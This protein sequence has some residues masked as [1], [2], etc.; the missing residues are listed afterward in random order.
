MLLVRHRQHAVAPTQNGPVH[1]LV[2]VSLRRAFKIILLVSE[3]FW[4]TCV[5]AFIG[6]TVIFS[7]G[8]TWVDMD[9]R[10]NVVAFALLRCFSFLL[11]TVSC[12]LNPLIYIL[13][14]KD[15]RVGCRRMLGRIQRAIVPMWN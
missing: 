6:R 11:T 15:I 5:P 2:T 13:V 10:R 8:T 3:T 4:L 7:T 9:T 14:H 1:S 12:L